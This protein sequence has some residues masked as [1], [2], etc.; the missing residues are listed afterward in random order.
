MDGLI[1]SLLSFVFDNIGFIVGLLVVVLGISS[2]KKKKQKRNEAEAENSPQAPQTKNFRDIMA[3]V[4][5]EMEK[6]KRGDFEP[7]IPYEPPRP[8]KANRPWD[9]PV[10][11]TVQGKKQ[12]AAVS[13]N[14]SKPAES[15]IVTP[16]NVVHQPHLKVHDTPAEIPAQVAPSPLASLSALTADDLMRGVVM[17]EVLGKPKAF[18]E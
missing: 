15:G 12:R 10:K 14:A 8:Q 1:A 4:Q 2:S 13:V 9:N 5:R 18:R 17:A 3:E 11:Q 7:Q 16:H 6:E